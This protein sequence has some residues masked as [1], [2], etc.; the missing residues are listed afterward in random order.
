MAQEN[1][2]IIQSRVGEVAVPPERVIRFPR[3]LIGFEHHKE[4]TLIHLK[5]DSPFHLLQSMDDPKLGLLVA[6]PYSFMTEYEVVVGEADRRILGVDDRRKVA[7]FVTVSI[8]VGRP[9]LTTLNLSGPLVVNYETRIGLQVPQTDAKYPSHYMPGQ[10]AEN[11]GPDNGQDGDKG[12]GQGNG[13]TPSG[14]SGDGGD[15]GDG[16][17][18]GK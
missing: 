4:F 6:D 13:R 8:P 12:G 3:G 10:A 15:G 16:G 18:G 2:R 17:S 11:G 7:L 1:E 14:T 9:E 5:E